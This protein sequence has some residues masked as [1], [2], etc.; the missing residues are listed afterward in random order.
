MGSATCI[1]IASGIAAVVFISLS[2]LLAQDLGPTV[3]RLCNPEDE[4]RCPGDA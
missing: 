2:G 3:K 4:Q 1:R